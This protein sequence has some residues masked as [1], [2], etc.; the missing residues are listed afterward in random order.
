MTSGGGRE[1]TLYSSTVVV[2]Q[3]HILY[4]LPHEAHEHEPRLML[5]VKA[6]EL[7][8]LGYNFGSAIFCRCFQ[9]TQVISS[10][11]PLCPCWG[12]GGNNAFTFIPADTSLQQPGAS[13]LVSGDAGLELRA[14]RI[15]L[16]VLGAASGSPIFG[17]MLKLLWLI[18]HH[19]CLFSPCLKDSHTFTVSRQRG[20]CWTLC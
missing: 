4:S 11:V 15:T 20:R 14:T 17:A 9:D 12:G 13:L 19:W 7:L 3:G 1:R 6:L 8:C 5:T 2:Q 18:S 10:L 16:R